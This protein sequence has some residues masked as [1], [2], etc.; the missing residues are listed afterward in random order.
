MS[1]SSRISVYVNFYGH[2]VD[3][4]PEEIASNLDLDSDEDSIR[5]AIM[6]DIHQSMV[7]EFPSYRADVEDV[8]EAV[9]AELERLK[10]EADAE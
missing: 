7:D 4:D 5:S 9:R 10:A 1:K 2:D 3:V 6:D 8:I